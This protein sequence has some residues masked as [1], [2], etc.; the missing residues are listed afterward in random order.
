MLSNFPKWPRE[1]VKSMI[2][3]LLMSRNHREKAGGLEKISERFW[4]CFLRQM[5][6]GTQCWKNTWQVVTGHFLKKKITITT[7]QQLNAQE[8][9]REALGTLGEWRQVHN[10]SAWPFCFSTGTGLS[11]LDQVEVTCPA[12]WEAGEDKVLSMFPALS[13]HTHWKPPGPSTAC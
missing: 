3:N 10:I 9:M 12:T 7:R 8:S 6:K 2:L 4:I 5:A 13:T 11:G 1:S